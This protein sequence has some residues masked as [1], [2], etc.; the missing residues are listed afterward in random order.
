MIESNNMFV[1][2]FDDEIP[3]HTHSFVPSFFYDK[4][5]T[6]RSKEEFNN[7]FEGMSVN[8][9]VGFLK[10]LKPFEK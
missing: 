3:M 8:R 7:I 6:F 10:G 1:V 9:T 2:S 5:V 4:K